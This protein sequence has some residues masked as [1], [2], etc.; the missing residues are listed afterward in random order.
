MLLLSVSGSIDAQNLEFDVIRISKISYLR[1]PNGE[2][3]EQILIKLNNNKVYKRKKVNAKYKLIDT[4]K[5]VSIFS[6]SLKLAKIKNLSLQSGNQY[7]GLYHNEYGYFKIELIKLNF[8][9]EI[10]GE[11]F[12]INQPYNTQ[13]K[14]EHE[15]INEYV[16]LVKS[17]FAEKI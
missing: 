7:S 14:E 10:Y 16:N 12:L 9:D 8:Q 17:L 1:K 2:V 13:E 11:S 3:K 15:L 4:K 6:D 5:D